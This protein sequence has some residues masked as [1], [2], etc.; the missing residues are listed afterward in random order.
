MRGQPDMSRPMPVPKAVL[1][2]VINFCLLGWDAA[3]IAQARRVG[4]GYVRLEWLHD[5]AIFLFFSLIAFALF[6]AEYQIVQGLTKRDLNLTLGYVQSLGCTLL[7]LCGLSGIYYANGGGLAARA[8]SMRRH[9]D[10]AGPESFAAWRIATS[11]RMPSNSPG[12]AQYERVA[13]SLENVARL[14]RKVNRATDARILEA[15]AKAMHAEV[16]LARP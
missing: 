12:S 13:D 3:I 14:L 6:F 7:V 4:P 15:K 10:Y 11:D 5:L 8:Q 9:G 2:I 1:R 16:P